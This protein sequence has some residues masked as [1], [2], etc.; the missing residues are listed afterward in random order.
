MKLVDEICM[1]AAATG[2]VVGFD[3]RLLQVHPADPLAAAAAQ[4]MGG[5]AA[6]AADKRRSSCADSDASVLHMSSIQEAL[7]A[8]DDGDVVQLLPGTHSVSQVCVQWVC[9]CVRGRC[10]AM[11]QL[12][13]LGRGGTGMHQHTGCSAAADAA[14]P[15]R[16]RRYTPLPD[17][18]LLCRTG[19]P[20]CLPRPS[21]RAHP[22][23]PT[24][25]ATLMVSKRI[26]VTGTP[27]SATQHV[28]LDHRANHPAFRIDRSCILRG[29]HLDMV[30]FCE[31]IAVTGAS[32]TVK[33]ILQDLL[34]TCSGDDGVVVS[35]KA[36]PLMRGCELR[37][38]ELRSLFSRCCRCY[39]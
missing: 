24:P 10:P 34:V 6:A 38:R 5:A 27:G 20:A 30:G 7:D 31:A 33:P 9:V 11:Q 17:T 3:G 14:K 16:P 8:A 26:M 13:Q 18:T 29:F 35:A 2:Q 12:Q 37:V 19:L 1:H 22:S 36:Q 23:L 25:Q 28:V 15:A 39:Y 4:P 32:T 21:R